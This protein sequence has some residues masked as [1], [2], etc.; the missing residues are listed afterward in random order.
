MS[1]VTDVQ[2][3]SRSRGWCFTVNNYTDGQIDMLNSIPVDSF[4]YLCFGK[5]IAPTTGTPHLQGYVRFS[6]IKSFVAVRRV[7]PFG[8]FIAARGTPRQNREYC[9]KGGDFTER[10][11]VPVGQGKRTDIDSAIQWGDD[12]LAQHGRAPTELEWARSHPKVHATQHGIVATFSLR[13]PAP[14]LRSGEFR[15]W[16]LNLYSI[17]EQPANDRVIY[18]YVDFEGGKGKTWFQQYM[19]TH[20]FERTQ[21]LSIGKR[22]DLAYIIDPSKD[23][24]LFNVPR[25]SMEYLQYTILEQLKDRM[26]FSTKYRGLTKFLPKTPHVVVF[27]NENPDYNRL[28][29]DRYQMFDFD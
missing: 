22:D 17:F 16:Q 29:G 13:A 12:F 1:T 15:P 11:V 14:D 18:F 21:V 2:S 26:V 25:G 6:S 7:I 8:H 27:S 9:S 28:S 23:I 4:H 10:G 20:H 3:T 5:E 19:V 24:F